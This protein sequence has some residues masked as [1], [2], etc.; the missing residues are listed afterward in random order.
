MT[1]ASRGTTSPT[2][3]SRPWSAGPTRGLLVDLLLVGPSSSTV[4]VSGV[5]TAADGSFQV[6][7]PGPLAD[8]IYQVQARAYDG[9][10]NQSFSPILT[11]TID[12][13]GPAFAPSLAVAA[14][15][16]HRGQGG[17]PHQPPPPVP[18]RVG[19]GDP[20]PG[21]QVELI[22]PAGI[23]LATTAVQ[24][25]GSFATQL[26]GDLV[27]GSIV[28]RARLRDAAGNTGP[29]GA[30]LT[31]TIVTTDGD[32]DADGRADLAVFQRTTATPRAAQWSIARSSLGTQVRPFGGSTDIP[33]QADFDGD[34]IED[35]VTFNLAT[36]TWFVLGSRGAARAVQFG[37]AGL[38]LPVPADYDGD[39]LTDFAVYQPTISPLVAS[40]WYVRG[41][42]DGVTRVTPFG[43]APFQPVPADYDGDGRAD[44]A[45]YLPSGAPFA[46]SQ[47]FLL[48]SGDGGAE[49]V[50]FGGPGHVAVPADYDGDGRTD[51]ATYFVS[52]APQDASVWLVRGSS[53]GPQLVQFGGGGHIPVPRDYDADGASG[54]RD[55]R[56]GLGAVV[57]A[58]HG[59][60]PDAAS[61]RSLA[62]RAG[63]GA[64]AAVPAAGVTAAA[65]A[66][67][68]G[69]RRPPRPPPGRGRPVPSRST[70][71]GAD[72]GR[73]AD[74]R[75]DGGAAGGRVLRT[76]SGTGRRPGASDP[77]QAE[78][79]GRPARRPARPAAPICRTRPWMI[80]P[81][82]WVNRLLDRLRG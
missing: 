73:P 21:A 66:P 11:L 79:Q 40:I 26:A 14:G 16:R 77:L 75:A 3:A 67:R 69:P 39:G 71:R 53:A 28:L 74:D 44:L 46:P 60:R 35:L 82:S 10:A 81:R 68:P 22:D 56:A 45:L 30:P 49:Q 47:W 70:R 12:T 17:R 72:R 43:G 76:P 62:R 52:G 64:A 2:S 9:A 59:E 32:Y 65:A 19:R 36:A 48:N 58:A 80:W 7:F 41:S 31:L 23:V 50:D 5:R 20:E 33:L 63:A 51:I 78:V 38:C 42:R 8:G 24:A 1:R 27:N 54:H 18:G 6:R 37:P 61:V 57:P 15:Q 34:G 13:T 55:V 25:D 29:P 4:L